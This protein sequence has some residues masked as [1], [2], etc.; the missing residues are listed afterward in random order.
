MA[1][2]KSEDPKTGGESKAVAVEADIFKPSLMCYRRPFKPTPAPDARVESRTDPINRPASHVDTKL[3]CL[4]VLTSLMSTMS[5]RI[6][7]V[8]QVF[9]AR[10]GHSRHA[11]RRHGLFRCVCLIL[12]RCTVSGLFFFF[13]CTDF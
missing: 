13:L 8:V 5:T 1:G 11:R 2:P 4:N 7:P 12:S 9:Q 3:K 6:Q 10:L